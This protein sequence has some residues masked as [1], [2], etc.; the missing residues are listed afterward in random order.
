[1]M[2]MIDNGHG[3]DTAGKRSPD[4]ALR[5]WLW[6]RQLAHELADRLR[7]YGCM[8][9]EIT[10]ENGDISL[11]ERVGRVNARCR[12][13]GAGNCA[14]ISLHVNAA[15]SDGRWHEARGFGAYVSQNASES[16]KRLAKAMTDEAVRRGLTG[17]RSVPHD[18][19]NVQSLA[20]CRDTL[21]AAV[22]TESAFMD[23]RD[24]CK[25]MLSRAG[26]TAFADLHA[27]A[28]MR[29]LET[30]RKIRDSKGIKP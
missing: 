26:L 8:V 30:E 10:P 11:K 19:Y 18:G 3:E 29:W 9:T 4:G 20:M 16:S 24:D 21:C 1:M 25:M 27:G 7:G 5:E 22:L 28:V 6:T 23:N 17:N 14:L 15:G 2:I 13:L 12:E